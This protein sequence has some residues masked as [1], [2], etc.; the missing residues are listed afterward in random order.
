MESM[1]RLFP[2]LTVAVLAVNLPTAAQHI[3]EK[4]SPCSSAF[5]TVEMSSCFGKARGA[6]DAELNT[7]YKTIHAKLDGE[8]EQRLVATQRLWIQYRDANCTAE[9]ELYAGGTAATP[10]YLAVYLACLGAMTRARTKELL[11]TYAVRLK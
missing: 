6:A 9:R 4:E 7:T 3:N 8:D 10:V 11:A 5:T 2:L 1:L